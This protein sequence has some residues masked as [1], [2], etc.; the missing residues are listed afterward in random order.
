MKATKAEME[1]EE[2]KAAVLLNCIGDKALKIY[3]TFEFQESKENQNFASIVKKFESHFLP[4]INVTYERYLFFTREM[5]ENESVDEYV[6]QLKHL[7]LNCEFNNLNDSLIKDRLVLGIK[8]KNVKDRLLRTKNLDLIKAVEICKSAEVT[9]KQLEVL[10]SSNSSSATRT[11]EVDLMEVRKKGK[12]STQRYG[13]QKQQYKK[14]STNDNSN[15]RNKISYNNYSN[16]SYEFRCT[17]C[18]S[19][20]GPKSC[21]AYG[22]KCQ[23]CGLM[24][25]FS[26]LC[27]N[28][29]IKNIEIHEEESSDNEELFI[30]LIELENINKDNWTA[31][32]NIFN[33]TISFKVDSGADVN[34]I[35]YVTYKSY[36]QNIKINESKI[37]LTEYTGTQINVL[38]YIDISVLFKSKKYD[39]RFFIAKTNGKPV[40]GRET[41]EKL[42][43]ARIV[44]ALS[45]GSAENYLEKYKDVFDGI[46]C[47]PGQYRIKI[48]TTVKPCI[49]AARRFPQAILVKL[50][51]KL[52]KLE[53]TN[54]IV[55]ESEPTEWVNSLVI[56]DKPNGDFRICIDPTD[57][58]KAIKRE[59]FSV[60][61]Y[62]DI[63]SCLKN[64]KVFSVLDANNGFWN[65]ALDEYSS[66]LCTF[67]TPFG[68]YRFK[69][70]PFGLKCSS[71]VFQR[72]I[73]QC[74]EGI[75][76]VHI[77]VD[78]I[79][80]WGSSK[81]EH[82]KRLLQVLERAR[83]CNIKFNSSK[84]QFSLNEVNYIGHKITSEGIKPDNSKISAIENYPEPTNIKELQ[85]FL[86]II[87][88]LHK[89]I[90]NVSELTAP[91]RELLKKD[92]LFR[93]GFE[94]KNAF[95]QL[96]KIIIKEPVLS[97]YD[98][99]KN[100]VLSVDACKDG[101]G[102][103][104][105]QE[106]KPIGYASRSLNNTQKSYAQIEK[107]MLAIVYG[108]KKFHQY[109]YGREIIVETDHKPLI[110]IF[111][112]PLIDCPM[113]L[114]RMLL[115]LQVYNLKVVYKPGKEMYISDA[116][117]RIK[118]P[119]DSA[120]I[121]DN[122][123]EAQLNY[124]KKN[125]P[126]TETRLK[127][128]EKETENDHE[129][130]IVSS[131]IKQGWPDSRTKCESNSKLYFNVRA[132]LVMVDNLVYKGNCLV[133]P[134]SLRKDMLKLIHL[135]HMGI[136]KCILKAK[137]YLYWPGMYR[138]IENTVTSCEICQKYSKNNY[139]EPLK[140]H[141]VPDY[142]W[143]KLG[144][145]LYEL[146]RDKY[147]IVVDYFSKYVEVCKV[148]DITSNTI[149]KH[150]KNIFGRL[151]IPQ[152]L[153]SD[154]G[155]Q[156]TAFE[157]K[158]FAE[159]WQF[160]HHTSSPHYPRSNG[161][162]ERSIQ[163]IKNILKK[164]SES[165]TD[166]DLALL[167]YRNTPIDNDI[168]TPSE[169]LFGR[170]TRTLMPVKKCSLQP[171][172]INFQRQRNN[173]IQRQKKQKMFHDRS[174]RKLRKLNVDEKI[175][176]KK[177]DV[178]VTGYVVKAINE[179]SYL[180]KESSTDVV[181]RR[182]RYFLKPYYTRSYSYFSETDDEDSSNINSNVKVELNDND[183]N[184]CMHSSSTNTNEIG[185]TVSEEGNI[186]NFESVNTDSNTRRTI[187]VSR[188]GRKVR[189]PK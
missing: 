186:D 130:K 68:R 94:Q 95:N 3:N 110:H 150:L 48:D 52:N 10:C 1:S 139:K 86:G 32:L 17:R 84:C 122:E 179:R 166:L 156:Y 9:H 96:K 85:C 43:I 164:C 132:E 170:K 159:N 19:I 46:G 58:N 59:Y 173:L 107:E 108:V 114:Q 64:A 138:E 82:D 124:L 160:Q 109:V 102:A 2:Y 180:V 151:G 12:N 88:Y 106:G 29:N 115:D 81:D 142:P 97:F 28:K 75:E 90:P 27:K 76:G 41:I 116:L 69:R 100:L 105:L 36:F 111:K 174:V 178:W 33:K 175:Y 149:V 38:G 103:V 39:V 63:I 135:S 67:N 34:V 161:M 62:T 24:N 54:I 40:L 113:R 87:N 60:P 104:L 57:L 119:Y 123:Y 72:K 129:L 6:T 18:G 134:K 126:I 140:P 177:G 154:N 184:D 141:R 172:N 11:E 167:D 125:F 45:D 26:K 99:S 66:K 37:K 145:D 153:M 16:Q 61:T 158:K 42:N 93:W 74:F 189:R 98:P 70:L 120:K 183:N 117:S 22:K 187:Y 44:G 13:R 101:L 147:L 152:I 20:H 171:R 35:P 89:F 55:K 118:M 65:I 181:M 31:D 163:T 162:V 50:K 157:F 7:S 77:Y 168:L 182:N 30:R 80:V 128:F 83:E 47:L 133:V 148:N 91:L 4:T 144:C 8:D 53:K 169:L 78:D 5:K 92:I 49:H 14:G 188:Y 15:Y 79:L 21:R 143:Q 131:Y 71:E 25:H 136:T 51:N 56:V 127:Q 137:Q 165:K 121:F 155:T 23:N 176:I 112:K 185:D 146:G 73:M